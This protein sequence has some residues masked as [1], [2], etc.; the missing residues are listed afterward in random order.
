MV[1]QIQIARDRNAVPLTRDYMT[2]A[3]ITYGDIDLSCPGAS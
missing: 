1:F 2:R 3:P